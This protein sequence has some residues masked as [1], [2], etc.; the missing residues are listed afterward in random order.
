KERSTLFRWI[1]WEFNDSMI[2]SFQDNPSN[3]IFWYPSVVY[4]RNHVIFT[5]V[6]FF[7]HFLPAMLIDGILIITG[8]K[9][10]MM[11]IYRKIRK[12]A[13]ATMELQRSDHWLYTDNTKR[14]FT[15]L[16]PVDKESFNFNIQS[17]NCAEYVRIRNYGIRYFACNEEDK[18]LPKARKNF[19]RY[20]Y[21]NL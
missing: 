4:V 8:K 3:Q 18:D 12:L 1:T 21:R 16:D 7:V 9:P 20:D 10:K 11:K 6:N 13:S 5:I 14:L 15:L 17:I 19:Q 2:E